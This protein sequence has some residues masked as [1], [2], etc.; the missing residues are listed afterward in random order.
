MSLIK[1][2]GRGHERCAHTKLLAAVERLDRSPDQGE[3]VNGIRTPPRSTPAPGGRGGRRVL[4]AREE[5]S[6]RG[7]PAW[8]PTSWSRSRRC[9]PPRHRGR[10]RALPRQRPAPN[11]SMP[12]TGRRPRSSVAVG[13]RAAQHVVAERV[14]ERGHDHPLVERQV[15]ARDAPGVDVDAVAEAP[16]AVEAGEVAREAAQVVA[17]RV[18]ARSAAR[19]T[20]R[21]A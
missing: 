9:P 4:V 12:M 5:A 6:T 10:V 18:A 16:P 19:G 14:A 21:A 8:P 1:R 17:R 15:G 13:E 20:R 2:A 11:C 7:S 3:R